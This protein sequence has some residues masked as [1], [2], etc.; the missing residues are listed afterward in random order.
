MLADL[1]DP[2]LFPP[3][4]AANLQVVAAGPTA[5]VEALRA[6]LR[7]RGHAAARFTCDAYG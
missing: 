7:D 2:R 5:M 4:V 6:G 1:A 3:A